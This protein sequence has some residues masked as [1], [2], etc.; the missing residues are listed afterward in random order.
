M[1]K[2]IVF[3]AT[4]ISSVSFSQDLVTNYYNEIASHSEYAIDGV[5]S[6]TP[7]KW[8][9][10]VKIFI[11]GVQDSVTYSELIKVISELNDLIDSIEIK[12]TNSES[13]ANL[14]AFFGWFLDYDKFEPNAERFTA[15]NYGLACVYMGDSSILRGSFYV[16]IV[17][18]NWFPSEQSDSLKKHIVRE[19]LTQSLGLLND[20]MKYTDSIFYQKWSL[21]NEYSELDKKIIKMH[22]SN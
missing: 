10:D 7:K 14:I 8:K 16:D 22:Y 21:I 17:R 19:E 11:K 5:T 9:T 3:I 12:I 4:F 20:S 13:E 18:C 1:K 6:F 2:L 15:S